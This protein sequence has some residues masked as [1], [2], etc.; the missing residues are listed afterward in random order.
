MANKLCC[1]EGVRIVNFLSVTK[2]NL[3]AKK[4]IKTGET[5]KRQIKKR[6][7]HI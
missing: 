5:K 2:Y 6:G 3:H 4:T 7:N 1:G